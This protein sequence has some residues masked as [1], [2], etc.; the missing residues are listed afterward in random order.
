MDGIFQMFSWFHQGGLVMYPLLFCSVLVST[1]A[2]ERFQYFKRG[3]IHTRVL[4]RKVETDLQ[5]KAWDEAE[6]SCLELGGV[7][8]RVLAAGLAFRGDRNAMQNAF[9]ESTSLEATNLRKNLSYLGTVVTMA[10]LLGLLGTV[11]GM[12]GSFRVLDVAGNNPAAIT[13]GVG[14]ALIATATGL[15]VAVFALSVHSY[16]SHRLDNVI[17]QIENSCSFVLR[18]ARGNER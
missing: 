12:I 1:I 3:G 6:R 16:F 10:P 17:T 11:V 5:N 7:V 8:G 9:E 2:V 18:C 15:C 13:G 4:I 14:E